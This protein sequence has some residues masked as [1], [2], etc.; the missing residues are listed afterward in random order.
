MPLVTN[1]ASDMIDE[2]LHVPRIIKFINLLWS[3]SLIFWLRCRDYDSG[4]SLLR[5]LGSYLR[6]SCLLRGKRTTEWSSW[7]GFQRGYSIGYWRQIG[8]H[9]CYHLHHLIKFVLPGGRWDSV[10]RLTGGLFFSLLLCL[11][12]SGSSWRYGVSTG[13]VKGSM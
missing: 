2:Y 5:R 4:G 13:P 6:N 9:F 10:V 12:I 7:L 11:L 8:F 1:H 3:L